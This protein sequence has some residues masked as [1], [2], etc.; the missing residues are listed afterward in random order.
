[1]QTLKS[2]FCIESLCSASISRPYQKAVTKMSKATVTIELNLLGAPQIVVDGTIR[3]MPYHKATALLA[4]LAVTA[5]AHSRD[6]LATFLWGH[7]DD[8]RAND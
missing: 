2:A 7:V 1:M 4:Y 8:Q 6:T 5:R 3:H